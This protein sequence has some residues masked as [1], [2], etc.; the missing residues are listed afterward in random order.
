METL[1][2][3]RRKRATNLAGRMEPQEIP[4]FALAVEL[5]LYQVEIW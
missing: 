5:S 4:P 2:A 1:Q 3:V